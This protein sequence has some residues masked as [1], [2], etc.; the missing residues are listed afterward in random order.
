MQGVPHLCHRPLLLG[1]VPQ[2]PRDRLQQAANLRGDHPPRPE[3]QQAHRARHPPPAPHGHD[4]HALESAAAPRRECRRL[5]GVVAAPDGGAAQQGLT[6]QPDS[7]PVDHPLQYGQRL[8]LQRAVHM[9]GHEAV[10]VALQPGADIEAQQPPGQREALLHDLLGGLQRFEPGGELLDG[11]AWPG[12]AA[13]R[14]GLALLAL[15]HRRVGQ[16]QGAFEGRPLAHRHRAVREGGVR[17]VASQGLQRPAQPLLRSRQVA[18][19]TQHHELVAA[20]AGRHAVRPGL[21][22]QRPRDP[23]QVSVARRVAPRVVDRPQPVEVQHGDREVARRRQLGVAPRQPLAVGQSGQRV[24]VFALPLL[25]TLAFQ[26]LGPQAA[27]LRAPCQQRH[28][29]QRADQREDAHA[30][31]QGRDPPG[32]FLP[33]RPHPRDEAAQPRGM[34]VLWGRA[35]LPQHPAEFRC[36]RGQRPRLPAAAAGRKARQREGHRGR[37]LAHFGRQQPGV[38]GPQTRAALPHLPPGPRRQLAGRR[39]LP[40]QGAVLLEGRRGVGQQQQGGPLVFGR[41]QQQQRRSRGQQ[42]QAQQRGGPA[43]RSGVGT[44]GRGG[45]RRLAGPGLPQVVLPRSG[46]LTPRLPAPPSQGSDSPASAY[47]TTRR[48]RPS[49]A[50]RATSPTAAAVPTR[51][52]ATSEPPKPAPVIRA[53]YTS[54]WACRAATRAST[55]GCETA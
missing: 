6:G 25:L 33:R 13:R 27:E 42:R 12:P 46:H 38:Q 23:A 37:A 55:T 21:R 49:P 35:V 52:S 10:P 53:P 44:S 45:A 22:P 34:Q 30:R 4:H 18:S 3:V 24:P 29:Q 8:R 9:P 41:A 28:R 50:P 43:A 31:R 15:V 26:R 51:T 47:G 7:L 36:D 2:A 19:G 17:A 5:G 40:L 48:A 16:G 1:G 20:P 11:G 54:G 39:R 14:E 32:F